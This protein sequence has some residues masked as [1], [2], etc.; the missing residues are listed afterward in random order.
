MENSFSKLYKVNG[1]DDIDD[2]MKVLKKT[3]FKYS[4]LVREEF[5]IKSKK[6]NFNYGFDSEDIVL[7][8]QYLNIYEDLYFPN[9]FKVDLDII[10]LNNSLFKVLIRHNFYNS[11]NKIVATSICFFTLK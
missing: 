7:V 6:S 8:E 5:F 4:K 11:D 10:T 2:F 1:Q 3:Y 9:L